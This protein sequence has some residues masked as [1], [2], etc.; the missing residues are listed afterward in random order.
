MSEAEDALKRARKEINRSIIFVR[1]YAD[2]GM[3]SYMG[4][5]KALEIARRI[6]NAELKKLKEVH[7]A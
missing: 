7:S 6:V 2:E 4:A 3:V 1:E 5:V